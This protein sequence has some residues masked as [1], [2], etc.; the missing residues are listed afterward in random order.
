MIA[1]IIGLKK[2]HARREEGINGRKKE[3]KIMWEEII[4]RKMIR[5]GEEGRNR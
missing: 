4:M 1:D 2:M 3:V 5:S